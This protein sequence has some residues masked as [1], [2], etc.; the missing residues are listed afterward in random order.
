MDC[1]IHGVTKSRTRLS[2]FHFTIAYE[3]AT[4]RA[5]F[6]ASSEHD[7]RSEF[8]GSLMVRGAIA[9]QKDLAHNDGLCAHLI[10]AGTTLEEVILC[11][12]TVPANRGYGI[13]VFN[14][15][16]TAKTY[17]FN[18]YMNILNFPCLSR[19]RDCKQSYA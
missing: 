19:L 7:P 8:H 18:G 2:D 3:S 9:L 1:I 14:P 13:A 12:K 5:P 4:R 10:S 16:L 17:A 15:V 6:K 11:S